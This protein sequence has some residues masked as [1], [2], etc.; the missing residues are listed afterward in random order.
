[1]LVSSLKP[2]LKTDFS[3]LQPEAVLRQ[4]LYFFLWWGGYMAGA[5]IVYV[6][7]FTSWISFSLSKGRKLSR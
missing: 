3:L 7:R 4:V 5:E 2:D 6:K 1:M